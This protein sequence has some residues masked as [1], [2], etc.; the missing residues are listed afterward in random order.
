MTTNVEL[1]EIDHRAHYGDD[2]ILSVLDTHD[3]SLDTA[4]AI[5]TS[6]IKKYRDA[7][8]K[9]I[10]KR[11]SATTRTPKSYKISQDIYNKASMRA[12]KERTTVANLV[13]EWLTDY[14]NGYYVKSIGVI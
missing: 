5:E 8:V 1:R 3:G 11:Q 10:N 6:W 7:G 4:T 13:E 9:L 14:S 12:K 2:I